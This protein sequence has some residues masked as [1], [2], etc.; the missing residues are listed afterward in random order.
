M[1]SNDEFREYIENLME[2]Y[3]EIN[4]MAANDEKYADLSR[5]ELDDRILRAPLF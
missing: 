2:M 5:K 4:K 3:L 1:V